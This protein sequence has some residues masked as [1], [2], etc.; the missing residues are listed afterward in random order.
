MAPGLLAA[1]LLTRTIPTL[2][3]LFPFHAA[4]HV[5]ALTV[6]GRTVLVR[7]AAER[8]CLPPL[9]L[10]RVFLTRLLG[11]PRHGPAMAPLL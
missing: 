3:A 11:L 1:S 8:V 7:T 10:L 9:P 5:A 4:P 2:C 6:R